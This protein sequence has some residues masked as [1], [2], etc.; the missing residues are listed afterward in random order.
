[1]NLLF[2][3]RLAGGGAIA[4][5]VVA[6]DKRHR[7][8]SRG[9]AE[10]DARR[11]LIVDRLGDQRGWSFFRLGCSAATMKSPRTEDAA[12][13]DYVLIRADERIEEAEGFQVPGPKGATAD[14]S[15]I[16]S[17]R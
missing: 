17:R 3:C 8:V 2:R 6:L 1:M 12:G 14:R 15:P 10:G 9:A 13:V 11:V 7:C 4:A 5:G 16:A